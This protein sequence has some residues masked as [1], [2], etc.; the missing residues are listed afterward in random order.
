MTADERKRALR[1]EVKERIRGLL[2][3]KFDSLKAL[4]ATESDVDFVIR[5][6]RVE[7]LW[8]IIDRLVE[9]RPQPKL[10]VETA[11]G[12]LAVETYTDPDYPGFTLSLNGEQCA[13][14]E[15]DSTTQAVRLHVWKQAGDET[16]DLQ[17]EIRPADQENQ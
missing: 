1:A 6:W 7:L 16:P 17:V 5:G 9:D 4:R 8:K 13:V 14:F 12:T 3:T 15:Y 11:G 2:E 10:E